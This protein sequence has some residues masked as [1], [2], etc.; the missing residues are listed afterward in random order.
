M[1][2]VALSQVY[3]KSGHATP[4][5]LDS[6]TAMKTD[7]KLCVKV[8]FKGVNGRLNTTDGRQPTG[9]EFRKG[10]AAAQTLPADFRA[11]FDPQ[12][13]SAVLLKLS[14]SAKLPLCLYYGTDGDP[15][16]NLTD[17]KD[18]AVPAFGPGQIVAD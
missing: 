2:G 15:Y 12:E 14:G 16:A 9:F 6:V 3:H 8:R 11:E 1:A 18:M 5:G 10:S 7:D 13:P 17:D 4:I